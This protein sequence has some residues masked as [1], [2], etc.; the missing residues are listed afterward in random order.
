M[1]DN[2]YVLAMYDVRGIQ[3]YIYKTAKVQDAIGASAIVEHIIDRA[4]YMAVK[5][6]EKISY[7]LEWCEDD[8]PLEY[9]DESADVQTLYI[10][11]G[12]AF[13]I[14]S[15]AE[16]CQKVNRLM[17]KYVLENTYSLQLAIAITPKTDNYAN[18]YKNLFDNMVEVKANMSVSNPLGTLPIMDIEIKT[19]LPMSGSVPNGLEGCDTASRE[20]YLKKLEE[21]KDPARYTKAKEFD[22]YIE[23][24]GDDSIIAV[25]HMDGNNMGLRI[26]SLISDESDYTKA[27]NLMRKI[28]YKITNSYKH[29]Y[30]EMER[31]FNQNNT[32]NVL[33][34]LVAGD[35]ITYVCKGKYA[36]STVEYLAREI[37]K[38]TMSGK[39][40]ESLSE[41]E[42]LADL[43]EYGFSVCA[44][45]SYIHSHFPFSVGYEVAEKC[46]DSA[47]DMAKKRE[48]QKQFVNGKG[49]T[50]Y[51]VG[52]WFDFQICKNVQAEDLDRARKD[53]Y[54]TAT[55]E[56]LLIRPYELPLLEL[57]NRKDAHNTLDNL[58]NSIKY[59][60]SATDK[61]ASKEVKSLPKSHAKALRNYYSEG[62]MAVELF[63]NFLESRKW[64]MPDGTLEMYLPDGV[65]AKWY[66]AI[67]LIDCY[68]ELEEM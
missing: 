43:D 66:D 57:D 32:N 20:T 11:G 34:I 38:E 17:S 30:E 10:G 40:A 55:G 52:N 5:S 51:K 39:S 62:K 60:Q 59:F 12:N 25:I 26:R 56:C 42:R 13:V 45:I 23:S 6:I 63:A 8:G 37:S 49:V 47:K 58:K 53:E 48:N 61:N 4:L 64:E 27:V 21:K 1:S 24:K 36:I 31:T 22:S 15:S 18:D 44:G 65:T 33:K 7:K 2:G 16:L 68:T 14:F 3:S 41:A 54:H 29:V 19:G 50:C 35:D 9:S 28:S 46:C 67:E